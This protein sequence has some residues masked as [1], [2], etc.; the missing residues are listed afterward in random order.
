MKEE[1]NI[2]LVLKLQMIRFIFAKLEN[3]ADKR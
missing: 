3:I 2:F 1:W